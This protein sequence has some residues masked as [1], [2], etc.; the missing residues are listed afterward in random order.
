M[1]KNH[2][3][4]S[5]F[6]YPA[7]TWVIDNA[8]LKTFTP[9]SI[10]SAKKSYGIHQ[11]LYLR[12][13]GR[14]YFRMNVKALSYVKEVVVGVAIDGTL[15]ASKYYVPVNIYREVSVIVDVV[16]IDKPVSLYIIAVNR[17]GQTALEF[18]QPV[19]YRLEDVWLKFALKSYL[20][21][22]LDYSP[23]YS[24]DNIL[25]TAR[26]ADNVRYNAN[27]DTLISL[28][29][30]GEIG[31]ETLSSIDLFI[32]YKLTKSHRYL[33]KILKEEVNHQGNFYISY[34]NT[35]GKDLSDY[36]SYMLFEYNGTNSPYVRCICKK[37]S[38]V[39]YR[40]ILRRVILVDVTDIDFSEE[41]IKSLLYV[42]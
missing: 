15:R 25:P 2:L 8:K 10:T 28:V 42:E 40:V 20:D 33:V 41:E 19:M 36:Q 26:F 27:S 30:Q 4:D 38:K 22:R 11:T 12:E 17:S 24:Y 5:E 13:K 7:H 35:K 39:P 3:V 1:L 32:H 16:D 34:N 9:F 37:N 31:V 14:Y 21:K 29:K 18:S 23:A 6:L